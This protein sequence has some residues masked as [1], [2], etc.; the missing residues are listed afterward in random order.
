MGYECEFF[1]HEK[2]DGD[3]D[4]SEVK[5]FKRKVGDPFEE[6]TLQKLA[7]TIMAQMARRD[8]LITD[9]KTFELSKK[10]ISFKESKN[11]I[12]LKN[13]KFLFDGG[14][15]ELVSSNLVSE[16]VKPTPQI[17][18]QSNMHVNIQGTGPSK[19]IESNVSRRPIDWVIFAPELLHLHEAKQ[20]GLRLTMDKKYPVY[21]KRSSTLGGEMFLIQD[22][23]GKEQEVSDK[24]FIPGNTTLFGD[25]E[26]GFSE[27][28]KERD[29]GNLYWGNA[30][31]EPDMPDVRRR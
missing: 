9:V 8:I 24:Y 5:T 31:H 13:K 17:T 7:A 30:N 25:K 14:I 29:G 26:L 4:K 22:D 23:T 21:L 10:E 3:Y 16:D 11:G 1:Y 27:S 28:P 6:V 15:E 12:V 20:K 19:A 2:V 18:N